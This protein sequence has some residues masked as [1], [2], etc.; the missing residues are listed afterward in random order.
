MPAPTAPAP[1][2]EVSATAAD[3][4]DELAE[5]VVKPEV[6]LDELGKLPVV[7]IEVEHTLRN[8]HEG[9]K[10]LNCLEGFVISSNAA[11]VVTLLTLTV[12]TLTG[13][14]VHWLGWAVL[15][16]FL[17]VHSAA[18]SCQLSETKLRGPPQS[19]AQVQDYI[20]EMHRARPQITLHVT[21][22]YE[23]QSLG[24]A[25]P[26]HKEWRIAHASSHPFELETCADQSTLTKNW[27]SAG[28]LET[29][30]IAH[31]GSRFTWKWAD[32]AGPAKLESAK[33]RLADEFK[34]KLPKPVRFTS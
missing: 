15:V 16:I 3:A 4:V 18:C 6:P 9:L 32:D 34:K 22:R 17:G 29:D 11:Y 21:C 26:D 10:G 1:A 7:P 12:V 31:L 13:S 28:S 8:R 2:P 30:R 23:Q 5:L 19:L 25:N 27:G 33:Q 24:G 14:T 20:A